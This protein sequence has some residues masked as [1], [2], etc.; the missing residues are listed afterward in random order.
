MHGSFDAWR[1]LAKARRHGKGWSVFASVLRANLTRM[2][3]A[4]SGDLLAIVRQMVQA[5]EDLRALAVC[6]SWASGCAGADSDLD[7]LILARAPSQWRE[8]LDWLYALPFE[9]VGFAIHEV[10]TATYGAVWSAHIRLGLTIELEI[11]FAELAWA[12][13]APLDCGTLRVV[14]DGIVVKIDKDRLLTKLVDSCRPIAK[15]APL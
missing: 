10:E 15:C 5:R 6:G 14:S 1:E 2:D 7:L 9:R 11:T 12:S 8:D 13:T 4:Q 3:S